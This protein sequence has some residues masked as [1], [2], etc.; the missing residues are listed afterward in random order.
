MNAV[1][2]SGEEKYTDEEQAAFTEQWKKSARLAIELF[3][4]LV[5]V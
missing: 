4:D 2:H 5:A 1:L 3:G